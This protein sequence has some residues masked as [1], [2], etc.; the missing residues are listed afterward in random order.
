MWPLSLL[1]WWKL[2]K[3]KSDKNGVGNCKKADLFKR[4][5][6]NL[7]TLTPTVTWKVENVPIELGGLTEDISRYTIGGFASLLFAIYSKMQQER[8]E[9]KKRLLNI[10]DPGIVWFESCQCLKMANDPK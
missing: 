10:K 6:E 7:V 4:V 9:L 8:H 5:A 1:L 3:K 2:K